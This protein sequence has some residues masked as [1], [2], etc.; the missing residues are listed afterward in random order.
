MD[1]IYITDFSADL[2]PE[3][4]KENNLEY[5]LAIDYIIGSDVFD[6]I[7]ET[8]AEYVEFYN[9]MRGGAVPRT[10][11]VNPSVLKERFAEFLK[12]GKDILY[13]TLS[14]GLSGTYSGACIASRE[15]GEEF[16]ERQIIVVDSLSASRGVGVLFN[17]GLQKAKSGASITELV[18]FLE[19]A[20]G[21]LSVE[22]TVDDLMYLHRGGRVSKVAAIAAGALDIKPVLRIDE[23]GK[24]IVS[25]KVRGR[26]KAIKS[27]ADTI[28]E[29]SQGLSGLTCYIAQCDC[30]SDAEK[31]K[32]I[33]EK[34]PAIENVEIYYC[35]AV[36]G[37]HAGPGI[38]GCGIVA[39]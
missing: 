18:T 38:L 20:R 28:F 3:Y 23:E 21:C 37:A 17:A 1:Y 22:F 12:E 19:N 9:K 39:M 27:L 10:S 4:Y 8:D 32:A 6:K 30:L 35:G 31:L 16:P 33:I 29:K 14:S 7:P 24:L 11:M 5:P 34:I 25:K 13:L 36:I 15:L 2:P 26:K